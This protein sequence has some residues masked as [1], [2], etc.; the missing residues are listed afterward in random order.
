MN[1]PSACGKPLN[2]HIA[3]IATDISQCSSVGMARNNRCRR[4][5]YYLQRS[6]GR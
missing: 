1:Y 6:L 5:V 4:I 3:Q 2:F